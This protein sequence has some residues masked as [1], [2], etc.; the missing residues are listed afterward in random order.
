MQYEINLKEREAIRILADEVAN[1][2]YQ[3][4]S[5]GSMA[6]RR[7]FSSFFHVRQVGAPDVY[8]HDSAIRT[9]KCMSSGA[10]EAV[11]ALLMA[12]GAQVDA[13]IDNSRASSVLAKIMSDLVD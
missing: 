8:T 1:A 2:D 9:V 4:T 13:D 10:Q 3:I 5:A 7:Y 11:I 12:V 6:F